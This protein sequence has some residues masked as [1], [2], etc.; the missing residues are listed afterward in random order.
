MATKVAT[1][2]KIKIATKFMVGELSTSMASAVNLIEVSSKASNRA[3]NFEYGR[4][5]ETLS[6][7]S[8]ATTDAS[9]GT[10]NWKDA[11]AA[12]VAATKV[13]VTISEYDSGGS[14]ESGAI[15]ISGTALISNCAL[16]APDNDKLTFSLD[17]TF[18]GATTVATNA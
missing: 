2:V 14:L 3:S 16:D 17:L 12:E 4:L 13:A 18:D 6:V 10:E 5:A 9:I 11:Q 7:S 15:I 1:L 8:I